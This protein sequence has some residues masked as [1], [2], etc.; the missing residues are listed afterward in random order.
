MDVEVF[1]DALPGARRYPEIARRAATHVALTERVGRLTLALDAPEFEGSGYWQVESE[2][3]GSVHATLY[4]S[5]SDVL[6]LDTRVLGLDLARLDVEALV[7]TPGVRFEPLLLDRWLHRNLLQLADL[8]EQRV[9]PAE[10]ARHQAAALQACWDVWT[11]G[12]LRQWQKPGLSQ[13]ERRRVFYRIFTRRSPLLPRH[14]QVF[15]EL[16]EGHL[17]DHEGLVAAVERLP[18]AI[19]LGPRSSVSS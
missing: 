2:R 17:R 13:A 19:S 5:P 8:L 18:T 12:R 3:D 4:G 15:H 16:W 9:R 7:A 14:W 10:V 1:P 6:R 11:D